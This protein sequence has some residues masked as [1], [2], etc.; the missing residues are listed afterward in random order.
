LSRLNAGREKIR[1]G[2]EHMNSY[3]SN[4]YKPEKL[5]LS[6]EGGTGCNGEP[7]SSVRGAM[8][9]N[10]LILA[11]ENPV[12]TTE[13]SKALGIPMAFIEESVNSLVQSQLL[14]KQGD[15][16]YTD[17]VIISLEEKKK[18]LKNSKRLAHETFEKADSVFR[19]T[20]E[21]YKEINGF[22]V[23][24][25]T[26]LYTM[27][28]LSTTIPFKIKAAEK[29]GYKHLDYKDYPVRPNYGKWITIASKY[30]GDFCI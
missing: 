20:V 24:N 30:P 10:I 13:L 14:K 1:K 26:Q 23:M 28:V 22:S 6:I 3:V 4:S 29:A 7:F 19:S 11:Y 27:A 18:A 25:D 21:K 9:K 16:V 15:K 2:A 17:F 12:N 5:I 8:D